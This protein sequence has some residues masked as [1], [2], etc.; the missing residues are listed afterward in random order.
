MITTGPFPHITFCDAV[1]FVLHLPSSMK[2]SLFRNHSD[3]NSNWIAPRLFQ[4][5]DSY[6]SFKNTTNMATNY[7]LI[8]NSLSRKLSVT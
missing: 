5:R 7:L 6:F 3:S 1:M 2:F 8:W 4:E